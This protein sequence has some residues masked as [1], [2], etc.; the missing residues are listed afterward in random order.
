MM[1][2]INYTILVFCLVALTPCTASG[3]VDS[4][5]TRQLGEVT[6]EG[7]KLFSIERL[8]KIISFGI[9]GHCACIRHT[10]PQRLDSN[11]TKAT[12]ATECK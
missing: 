8:P 2:R 9:R 3:Q 12:V 1:A 4:L 6:I 5:S 11:S 7:E 10:G